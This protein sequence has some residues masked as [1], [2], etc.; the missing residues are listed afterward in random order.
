MWYVRN[1]ILGGSMCVTN[2][3]H[4]YVWHRMFDS[5]TIRTYH[6]YPS[7][8]T[9]RTYHM[10]MEQSMSHIWIRCHTYEFDVTH[11]NETHWSHFMCARCHTYEHIWMRLIVRHRVSF[12]CV[13]MC[14][15]V[16]HRCVTSSLIHM[17]SYVWHRC[18]T[19]EMRSMSLIHMWHI[20]K[21][22]NESHI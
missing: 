6:I 13:H 12:I 16:W 22:T 8:I 18:D 1:V 2:V 11:M 21:E 19:Y 3:C 20:W 14:S 15:Y 4:T 10:H 5:I 9:I 7:R 17:C